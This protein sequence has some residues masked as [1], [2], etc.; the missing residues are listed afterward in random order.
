MPI[1]AGRAEKVEIPYWGNQRRHLE[2]GEAYLTSPSLIK[3]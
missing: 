2:K 1:E 3:S